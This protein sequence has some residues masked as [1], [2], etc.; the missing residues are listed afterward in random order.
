MA[1]AKARA[2]AS[3]SALWAHVF[4]ASFSKFSAWV[5]ASGSDGGRAL[6]HHDC[7]VIDC[8]VFDEF[9]CVN[10]QLNAWERQVTYRLE[11]SATFRGVVESFTVDAVVN[12]D[13]ADRQEDE[14]CHAAETMCVHG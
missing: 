11:L 8:A 7:S 10:A 1:A 12:R 3:F 6:E 2:A 14:T 4:S 9:V 13:P 5:V